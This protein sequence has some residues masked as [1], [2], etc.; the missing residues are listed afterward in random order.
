MRRC[1]FLTMTDLSGH[2]IDDQRAYAPLHDLGWHIEAVPWSQPGVA[3]Q[4]YDLVVIR[5]AWD[6]TRHLDAFLAVLAD[7]EQ[8][9]RL[10]NRLPLVRWN[11]SKT[12]LRELAASGVATVPTVW[13]DRL[14]SGDLEGLFEEVASEEIVI[15]P[16]VGASAE[17]AYR[18][19]AREARKMAGE[20]EAF[21]A[22]R[23]LQ[24]QPLVRAVLDE[25]EYSLIY[26]NGEHSHT[27]LKTPKSEDFRVQEEHGGI[28][29]AVDAEKALHDAGKA[30]LEILSE[31]PLYVRVDFVRANDSDSFWLMELEL[32][33]PSLYLRLDP[34][35]PKR[36]ARALDE[37]FSQSSGTRIA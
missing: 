20:V 37:R 8:H 30:V 35:A 5:S 18:I 10:E 29:R 4:D 13:R 28:I 24:A 25:G 31:T 6:Y 7:I 26:F 21:Y 2:V 32:V 11:T 23:A 27:L 33:E 12:Y 1:A 36:F 16:V 15:K 34:E 19:G 14:D 3:W 22:R 17:G 9:A